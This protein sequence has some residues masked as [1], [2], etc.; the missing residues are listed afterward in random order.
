RSERLL[1]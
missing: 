1:W